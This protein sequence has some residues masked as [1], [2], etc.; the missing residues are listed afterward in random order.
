MKVIIIRHG[1]IDSN[2]KGVYHDRD[3]DLNE[4][5]IKQALELSKVIDN[6]SY[7]VIISSPMIRG[8]HTAELINSHNKEILI[9]ERLIERRVGSLVGKP[10]NYTNREEH[11]NYYSTITYGSEESVKDLFDRVFL[12]LDEL[13]KKEY[14][15]VLVVAHSGISRA[16]NGYFNGINDG[17]FLDKGLQNCEF[18]E[19]EF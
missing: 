6:I 16:F 9:D 2:D 15:C 4:I 13:K 1:Q 3:E 17:K 10:V 11:W 14:S 19:Y 5:G 12:F 7:D 8:I 18:K